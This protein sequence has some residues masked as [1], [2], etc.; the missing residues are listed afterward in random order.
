MVQNCEIQVQHQV[1]YHIPNHVQECTEP[2]IVSS[3]RSSGCALGQHRCTVSRCTVAT[4]RNHW[5]RT[6]LWLVE[7][8]VVHWWGCRVDILA[9]Q[10]CLE[11][12]SADAW[13]EPLDDTLQVHPGSLTKLARCLDT[14]PQH[15]AQTGVSLCRYVHNRVAPHSTPQ[16]ATHNH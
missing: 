13:E 16:T 4:A 12:H 14:E 10:T 11:M 6:T 1:K 15:P 3:I 7:D 9:H 8:H 5:Q 2:E